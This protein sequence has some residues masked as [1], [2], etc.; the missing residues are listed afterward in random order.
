MLM[1]SQFH[2]E[3]NLPQ[4]Y[5]ATQHTERVKGANPLPD[6]DVEHMP[7]LAYESPPNA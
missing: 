1:T 7:N 4:C 5:A 3:H 6:T 2:T